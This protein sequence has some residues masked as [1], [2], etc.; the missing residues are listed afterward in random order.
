M[1]DGRRTGGAWCQLRGAPEVPALGEFAQWLRALTREHGGWVVF[2]SL[3][4]A[5]HGRVDPWGFDTP[6]RRLMTGIKHA[7]DPAGVFS[8]GRFVGGI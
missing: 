2:E 7:L 4:A 3:P 5:L 6:A 1:I 8:P